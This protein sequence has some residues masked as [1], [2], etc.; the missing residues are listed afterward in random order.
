MDL[1]A[2]AEL[3][4]LQLYPHGAGDEAPITKEEFFESARLEYA[5]QLLQLYWKER[6]EFGFFTIPSYLLTEVELPVE[7]NEIDIST[8]KI[9]RSFS[10]DFWLQNIGGITCGCTYVKTDVNVSQLMCDDDSMDED[11]RTYVVIGNKI[12]FPK[13]VHKSPLTI[14][15]TNRGGALSGD[16]EVDDAIAGIVRVRLI[17]IYGGGKTGQE[18]PTNNSNSSN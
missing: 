9:F 14:I 7:N 8:L 11:V 15:Y 1:R 12:K 6:R 2:V 4:W 3:S 18:D 17:E 13:G 16:L 5:Y 10:A